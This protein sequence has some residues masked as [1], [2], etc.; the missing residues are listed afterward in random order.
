MASFTLT[1]AVA[2]ILALLVVSNVA[3][4]AA[5]HDDRARALLRPLGGRAPPALPPLITIY[6]INLDRRPDRKALLRTTMVEEAGVP[7]HQLHRVSAEEWRAAPWIGCA[8]SHLAAVR[9]A[10]RRGAPFTL[11]VEDD[12]AWAPELERE[13]VRAVVRGALDRAAS[14]DM[15]L[16]AHTYTRYHE[17]AAVPLGDGHLLRPLAQA[18]SLSAYLVPARFLP[19]LAAAMEDIVSWARKPHASKTMCAV[20]VQLSAR[21]Y[22]GGR[23]MGITP[24]LLLQRPGVSDLE[25]GR[26]M[27]TRWLHG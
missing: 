13:T 7:P 11:I 1:L 23:V 15:C 22:G 3:L 10:A 14:W 8:M 9:A 5:L 24:S 27:D 19:V 17:G 12:V 26:V 4:A 2:A 25:G 6:Y 21:L 16:L 18:W 20:D